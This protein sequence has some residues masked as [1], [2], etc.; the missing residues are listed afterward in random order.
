MALSSDY[1]SIIMDL[2]DSTEEAYKSGNYDEAIE[3]MEEVKDTVERCLEEL[4]NLQFE[5]END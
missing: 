2:V 4:E 1:F 5:E 3:Y